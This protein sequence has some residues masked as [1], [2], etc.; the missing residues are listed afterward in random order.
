MSLHSV[1][2]ISCHDEIDVRYI[3]KQAPLELLKK[4]EIIA[5]CD[6]M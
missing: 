4:F 5:P 3:P 2:T 1:F 6:V